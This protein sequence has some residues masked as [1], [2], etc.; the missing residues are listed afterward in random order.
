[1]NGLVKYSVTEQVFGQFVA[2]RPV[3]SGIQQ[4]AEFDWNNLE[5]RCDFFFPSPSV[6]TLHKIFVTI[7]SC[8][9]CVVGCLFPPPIPF[10]FS[11]NELEPVWFEYSFFD[12]CREQKVIVSTSRAKFPAPIQSSVHTRIEISFI[13]CK[14]AGT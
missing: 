11:E 6:S 4:N 1:V 8:F 2:M 5:L 14:S 12:T 10:P 3:H 13:G 7:L 9:I